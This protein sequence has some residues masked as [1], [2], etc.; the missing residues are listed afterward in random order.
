MS[1]FSELQSKVVKFRDDRDWKQFHHPKD[2][3]ISLVLEASEVLEHFQWRNS[4]ELED[5]LN[6][7]K[8]KV[9]EELA[10]VFKYLLLLSHELDID[11]IEATYNK[12]EKDAQKYPVDK[13]KGSHKKYN[14]L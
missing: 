11:L 3:A 9:V 6:K 4:G 10:D 2:L 8:S 7:E 1:D 5:Y 14:E 13:A 12:M